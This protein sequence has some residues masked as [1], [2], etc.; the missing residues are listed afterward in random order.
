MDRAAAE[1]D[2]VNNLRASGERGEDRYELEQNKLLSLDGTS[3]P[4]TRLTAPT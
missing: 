4:A 2:A 1:R 3:R